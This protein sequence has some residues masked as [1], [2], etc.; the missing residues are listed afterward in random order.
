MFCPSAMLPE[1]KGIEPRDAVRGNNLS[2]SIDEPAL[3]Q[4]FY[5]DWLPYL[6][7]LITVIGNAWRY[8][9]TLEDCADFLAEDL[10]NKTSRFVGHRVGVIN[11]GKIKQ[12]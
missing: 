1:K 12:G 10:E 11:A 4:S 3:M 2:S 9:T 6:G 5:I 8:N 7:P